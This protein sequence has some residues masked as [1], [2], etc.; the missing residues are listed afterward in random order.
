M[1][2]TS[3]GQNYA[4]KGISRPVCEKGEFPV[5]VI[6]LDH[7]HIYGM[8]NGLVEAGATIALVWDLDPVKLK[9]FI[10]EYPDAAIA[11]SEEEVLENQQIRLIASAAIPCRRGE[12]GIRV[13][14]HGKDYFTDKPPFTTM[15]Q[16]KDAKEWVRKSG[17][18]F[19]VYYSERLHVEGA[20][21]VGELIRKGAVGR[22]VQVMGWGPHRANLEQRPE[23]FFDK[24]QYGGILVDTGCHQIEQIL[25]YAGAKNASIKYSQ[26]SNYKY[27]DFP[28]ME[29]FGSIDLVCDNGVSGYCRVDWLTPDGLSVWGDGRTLIIGTT[30]YIE[31]RKYV[32][33]ATDTSG[34]HVFLVNEEGEQHFE[35]AGTCGFP[36]F[37]QLIRDCLDRTET[38]MDQELVFK[39]I[40]LAIEAEE[41][42]ERIE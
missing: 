11:K 20:V 1:H 4:P 33:I 30:G 18:K 27:K 34:D 29:D 39:A 6:G 28:G 16:L 17:C 7:G 3:D 15:E 8:C 22:V 40:E 5:G 42:A 13:M 9:K 24:Q 32:N 2:Q 23:W 26:V 14:K 37:G 19:A 21:Y 31:L 25:S 35:A 38:A 12:L 36:F 10:Q 41:K